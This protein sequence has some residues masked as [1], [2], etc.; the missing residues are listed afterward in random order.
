LGDQFQL[1]FCF[2]NG[3]TKLLHL[4]YLYIGN[5]TGILTADNLLVAAML[6]LVFAFRCQ[7]KFLTSRHV[8]MHRVIFCI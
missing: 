5:T 3:N 8:R 2:Y 7:A 6:C 1:C 4:Q